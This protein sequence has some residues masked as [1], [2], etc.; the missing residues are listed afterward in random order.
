MAYISP[1]SDVYLCTAVPLDNTYQHTIL[2][3]DKGAQEA[4]FTTYPNPCVW[5]GSNYSYV[6]DGNNNIVENKVR[7]N[8]K[9]SPIIEQA[10]YICYKNKSHDAIFYCAFITYMS[11]INENCV[12]IGFE[13]DI[14]QTYFRYENLH[15]CIV[16]RNTIPKA[17]DT[18]HTHLFPEPVDVSEYTEDEG[19]R[20]TFSTTLW[21][22]GMS[23]VI[24]TTLNVEGKPLSN[25]KGGIWSGM[26]TGLQPIIFAINPSNP[27]ATIKEINDFLSAANSIGLADSIVTATVMPRG[28]TNEMVLRDNK[29]IFIKRYDITCS[30]GIYDQNGWRIR[31]NKIYNY[32]YMLLTLADGCGRYKNYNLNSFD[33]DAS[34]AN[35]V[36]FIMACSLSPQPQIAMFPCYYKGCLNNNNT[37][38]TGDSAWYDLVAA[39]NSAP[40]NM[41]EAFYMSD[42]P[43]ITLPLPSFL[44][45]IAYNIGQVLIPNALKFAAI[46]AATGQAVGAAVAASTAVSNDTGNIIDMQGKAVPTPAQTPNIKASTQSLIGGYYTVAAN[47]INVFDMDRNQARNFGSVNLSTGAGLQDF[48]FHFSSPRLRYLWA[49]DEF[50]TKYGY[51]VNKL[52]KPRIDNRTRYTY[53]KTKDCSYTG[54]APLS[55]T[56]TIESIFN[57]GI[58]FWKNPAYVG[59]YGP[60]N[61]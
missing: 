31:N 46:G 4:W 9:I 3:S 24:W 52:E 47:A 38:K 56:N 13:L 59:K 22:A 10:N 39:L 42:L 58:T 18:Y 6:R 48:Y 11:Y 32:P 17:E 29:K 15:E 35:T 19:H 50:W 61:N 53:V 57:Q 7:I 33:Y 40:V 20:K 30:D 2:W 5:F 41:E 8:A 37:T 44:S 34:G 55:V 43:S 16:E 25:Y 54:N 27:D 45:N 28:I 23:I 49:I 51:T 14:M 36:R 12:E 26:Y 1:N 60:Q 21:K